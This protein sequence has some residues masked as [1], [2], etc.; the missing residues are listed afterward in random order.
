MSK[1]SDKNFSLKD[2]IGPTETSYDVVGLDAGDYWFK[3]TTLDI[4]GNESEGLVTG[5]IRIAETGPSVIGL[6]MLSIGLG[7][8]IKRKKRV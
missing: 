2:S 6:L 4:D 3:I 7:G 8:V 5:K 1:N